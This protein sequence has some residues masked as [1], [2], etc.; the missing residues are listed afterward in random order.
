M[1]EDMDAINHTETSDFMREYHELCMKHNKII[2]PTYN[3]DVSFHDPM[4]VIEYD[5][6]SQYYI[7]KTLVHRK[8]ESHANL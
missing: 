2:V 4:I 3:N 5:K 7:Q 1:F 8:E 6:M